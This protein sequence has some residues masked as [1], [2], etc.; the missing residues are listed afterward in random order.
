MN[1]I[2]AQERS[3]FEVLTTIH[4][5]QDNPKTLKDFNEHAHDIQTGT[6]GFSRLVSCFFYLPVKSDLRTM[7]TSSKTGKRPLTDFS[8]FAYP[9]CI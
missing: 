9:Q 3:L 4:W 2:V 8:V 6:S 5:H 7:I 1:L